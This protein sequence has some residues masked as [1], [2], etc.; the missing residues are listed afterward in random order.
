[1]AGRKR[2]RSTLATGLIA[3]AVA[4]FLLCCT[5]C[6]KKGASKHQQAETK[7]KQEEMLKKANEYLKQKGQGGGR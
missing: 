7:Q 5:G 6:P 1:M 4:A 2:V 3:V